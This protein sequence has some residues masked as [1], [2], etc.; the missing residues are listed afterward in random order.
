MA[1]ETGD[2]R[3]PAWP[4]KQKRIIFSGKSPIMDQRLGSL[5]ALMMARTA[6]ACTSAGQDG[7]GFQISPLVKQAVDQTK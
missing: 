4:L 1:I 2:G 6:D 5:S 7:R 3:S